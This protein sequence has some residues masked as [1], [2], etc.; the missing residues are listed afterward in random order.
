MW[1]L[2]EEGFTPKFGNDLERF[3]DF[4]H[5]TEKLS[6]AAH[7]LEDSAAAAGRPVPSSSASAFK[8]KSVCTPSEGFV[9]AP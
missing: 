9:R 6:A 3:V 1:N 5:T 7:A 2:L 8:Y 4:Y